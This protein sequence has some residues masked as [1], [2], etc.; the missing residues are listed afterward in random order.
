MVTPGAFGSL[1]ALASAGRLVA[2][3]L[4]VIFVAY[5]EISR[6]TVAAYLTGSTA[7]A[8]STLDV[9]QELTERICGCQYHD[10]GHTSLTSADARSVTF[11]I[12]GSCTTCPQIRYTMSLLEGGMHHRCS[13]P[14][15]VSFEG[16]SPTRSASR[17]PGSQLTLAAL[18]RET[19]MTFRDLDAE[20]DRRGRLVDEDIELL[21]RRCAFRAK[22]A[23]KGGES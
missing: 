2:K 23:A 4:D 5:G 13:G 20:L 6:E 22:T 15:R 17:P 1:H 12:E 16:L 3:D 19:G 10:G 7:S 9:A 18:M 8:A 11:R 14:L 21:A